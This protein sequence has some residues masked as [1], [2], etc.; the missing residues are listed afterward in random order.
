MQNIRPLHSDLCLFPNL[1]LDILL[2][3]LSPHTLSFHTQKSFIISYQIYQTFLS[4]LNL[5]TFCSFCL[6]SPTSLL[7]LSTITSYLTFRTIGKPRRPCQCPHKCPLPSV[8]C[9][10]P[11]QQ[12]PT[13]HSLK[14]CSGQGSTVR[15]L[16]PRSSSQPVKSGSD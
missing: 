9:S 8:D 1:S 4:S 14:T 15:E 16:A 13:S 10:H 5:C 11:H 2:L 3:A 12:F 7:P 6:E